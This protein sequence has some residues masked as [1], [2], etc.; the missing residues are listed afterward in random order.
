MGS[1]P[2]RRSWETTRPHDD[3]L[4]RLLGD[5]T[6]TCSD[7]ATK[8]SAVSQPTEQTTAL[9]TTETEQARAAL[10]HLAIGR[11]QLAYLTR[12]LVQMSALRLGM[13][14]RE[15]AEHADISTQTVNRWLKQPLVD[16]QSPA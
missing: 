7:M 2:G 11:D 9:G 12:V 16:Q 1:L 3:D 4:P 14:Q 5:I 13:T 6:Q 8:I 10:G 15:S